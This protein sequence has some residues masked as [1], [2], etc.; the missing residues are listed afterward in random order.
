MSNNS[1][2][3]KKGGVAKKATALDSIRNIQQMWDAAISSFN[4]GDDDTTAIY[5]IY[6]SMSP[7]LTFQDISNVVGAVFGATYWSGL[8]MDYTILS[9]SLVQGL[10]IDRGLADQLAQNSFQQWRGM[11]CRKNI[12]DVGIIPTPGSYTESLDIVCNENTPLQ[13]QQLIENWNNE[14]WKTPQIGKNYIYTRTQN[15]GFLGD[16]T[17]TVQMF[18]TTGGFNQPP[19][20]WIQ[21]FTESGSKTHGDVILLNGK[22]GAMGQGVRGASEAFFFNPTSADH[23]CVI[24]VVSYDFFDDNNPL[25]LKPGN[26]NS[27]TWITHNGAAAW[28]NTD[29]QKKAEESFKFYNQDGTEEKFA[30]QVNCRNVPVG[31][32]IQLRNDD[33]A[34]KFDTGVIEIGNE[35]QH[36]EKIVT[37]P[38]YY[39]GDL[40]VKIQGPDGKLLPTHAAVEISMAWIVEHGHRRYMDAAAQRKDFAA[41]RNVQDIF[42][43]LG[44]FTIT[45]SNLK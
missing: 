11:L 41:L 17:P 42:L 21:C 4:D 3:S 45:G 27:Q 14:F 24:A 32:T 8:Q 35:S 15:L 40:K 2:A 31:S 38:A 36:I 13:P 22:P 29:P 7:K 23:V 10:G 19:S 20:S 28:H 6:K 25:N 26:W 16:I 34:A 44:S 5:D 39:K 18:Y 1:A 30:F 33:S 37:L 43:P 9:K 12:A